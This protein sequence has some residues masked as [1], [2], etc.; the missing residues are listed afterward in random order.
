MT[1]QMHSAV[2]F[3]PAATQSTAPACWIPNS[4]S[5][6]VST[7][8]EPELDCFCDFATLIS[9]FRDARTDAIFKLLTGEKNIPAAGATRARQAMWKCKAKVRIVLVYDQIP[10]QI[11]CCFCACCVVSLGFVWSHFI[12]TFSTGT[13][14][15]KPI[16]LSI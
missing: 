4:K 10:D 13:K 5:R 8:F 7:M 12:G 2:F 1:P 14:L 9:T 15:S 3:S 11:G 16:Y 6:M